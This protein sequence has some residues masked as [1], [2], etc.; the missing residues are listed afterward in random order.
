MVDRI[1]PVTGA[2]ERRRCT[3]VFGVDD[4]SPVFCETFRQW[5]LEDRF[6]AGRP[7]LELAGVTFV[8][9]VTPYENMKLRIL[10]G[11]HVV[12]AHLGALMGIK[13]VSGEI[14]G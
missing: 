6:P 1:T 3:Q 10:N 12:L 14:V 4:A 5:V 9:D 11:G 8:T 2:E 7:A 13:Y